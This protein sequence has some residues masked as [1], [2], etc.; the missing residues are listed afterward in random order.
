MR[1]WQVAL[2]YSPLLTAALA[3]ASAND[4]AVKAA[5]H[6][7]ELTVCREQAKA[8]DAGT[9]VKWDAYTNCADGVDARYRGK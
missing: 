4:S 3:C 7:A 1:W 9:A 5:G 8:L 2:G 6:A